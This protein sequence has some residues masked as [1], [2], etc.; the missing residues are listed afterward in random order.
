VLFVFFLATGMAAGFAPPARDPWSA[1]LAMVFLGVVF[2]SAPIRFW[3]VRQNADL[4]RVAIGAGPATDRDYGVEYRMAERHS[5]WFIPS[6]AR[7]VEI[8]LRLTGGSQ[9]CLVRVAVEGQTLNTVE[10]SVDA[11]TRVTFQLDPTRKGPAWLSLDLDVQDAAC[12]LMVG[13]FTTR[14]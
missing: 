10:P 14:E 3:Q 9:Q 11:W 7:S 2:V 8:P 12:G 1:R 6:R 5:E 13:R 4:N